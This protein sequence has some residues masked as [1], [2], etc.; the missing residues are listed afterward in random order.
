MRNKIKEIKFQTEGITCA[1]YAIDMENIL[2][3]KKGI[4]DASVSYM[5]G[6]INIRYDPDVIKRIDVIYNVRK[7]GFKIKPLSG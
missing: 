4:L 1:A 6:L 2:L 5:E 3:A 7:L